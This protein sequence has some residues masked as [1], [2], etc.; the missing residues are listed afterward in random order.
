MVSSESIAMT[1]MYEVMPKMVAKPMGWGA[2]ENMEDTWFVLCKFHE[3]SDDIPD[4]EFPALVAEMHKRAVSPTGK[5][6][7]PMETFG[8]RNPQ[9]FPTSDTWVECFSTGLAGIIAAETKT[10][11]PDE[12]MHYLTTAMLVKVIPRLLGALESDGRKIVP[13]LVHGDLWEGN[14]S[15][16]RATGS[17]MMFDATPIYA[18]NECD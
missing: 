6:G 4:E 18:H 9:N 3:M 8:G 5:F 1:L 15:V 11:G 17:P 2:Y 13:C 7:Y 12:E 14:A 10:Q 16:D